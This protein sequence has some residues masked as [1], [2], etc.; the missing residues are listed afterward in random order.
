MRQALDAFAA[1]LQRVRELGALYAALTQLTTPALDASD[2]LRAQIVLGV[3]AL[4][5]YVHEL[6]RLGILEILHGRRAA[7]AALHRFQIPM[8]LHLNASGGVISPAE[9]DT[10]IRETHG[11]QSFQSPE[12]IADAIRL[13]S[14]TELWNAVGAELGIQPKSARERLAVIVD[15]RNKIAH[16]ADSD[17]SSPGARWP[18]HK[19]DVDASIVYLS[20]VCHSIFRVI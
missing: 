3:S 8:S 14:D 4:D 1:N 5:T 19:P 2:I 15:R 18:I 12:K 6:T 11:Y 10:A 20:E 16:E 7:T 9:I 17:P 13:I